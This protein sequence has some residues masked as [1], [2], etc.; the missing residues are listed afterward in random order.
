MT[1]KAKMN[2]KLRPHQAVCRKGDF[3]AGEEGVVAGEGEGGVAYEEGK[4]QVPS[5][6]FHG[7]F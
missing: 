6:K 2:E 5:S 3:A 4:T 7:S 1:K